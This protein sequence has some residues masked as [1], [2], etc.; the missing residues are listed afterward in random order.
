MRGDEQRVADA[1]C[2]WLEGGG[3]AV[4]REVDFCDLVATRNSEK[5][6]CEAKGRTAAIGLDIDTLY[7]QLLRRM[8]IADDL[9]AR[10]AVVVPS[11]AVKA[12]T[13]VSS[14]VRELLRIDVYAVDEAGGV[15]ALASK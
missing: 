11:E 2:S 8:P 12:A 5:L 14:R 9:S 3:W 1:F 4:S 13:R 15:E 10:F 7:G 6:Y